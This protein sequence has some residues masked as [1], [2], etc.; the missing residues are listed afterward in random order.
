MNAVTNVADEARIA[1]EKA[2]L[3]RTARATLAA[4]SAEALRAA[5][6]GVAQRVLV[7]TAFQSARHVALY[8]GVGREVRTDALLAAAHENGMRVSLPTWVAAE[9]RYY[10]VQ[11]AE[12]GG[13]VPGPLGIPQ[14]ALSDFADINTCDLV[15]VPGL[16]FSRNGARLGHGGG[17]Y[18][19]LLAPVR[20]HASCQRV[21][22]AYDCQMHESVPTNETDI[23]MDRIV[24][25]NNEYATAS[26]GATSSG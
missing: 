19:R 15:L 22:L 20:D 21:A 9:K 4:C 16:A 1:N 3:R 26:R 12:G 17:H 2:A 14:P 25:E 11:N 24:T 13:L 7:S 10:F 5:G 23:L 6:D 18:D 8:I